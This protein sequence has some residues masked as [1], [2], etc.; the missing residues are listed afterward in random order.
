VSIV[1]DTETTDLLPGGE[2]V[3]VAWLYLDEGGKVSG[4]ACRRFRPNRPITLGAMAV[5]N[6]LPEELESEDSVSEVAAMMA[7]LVPDKGPFYVIGHRPEFDWGILCNVCPGLT[8][9]PLDP[10]KAEGCRV[11]LIDTL[12]MARVLWPEFDSHNLLACAYGLIPDRDLVR[13]LVRQAHNALTDCQLCH[14]ILDFV[15]AKTMGIDTKDGLNWKELW[16]FSEQCRVPVTMPFGKHKGLPIA[17]VPR[18]YVAWLLRQDDVDPYL[19]KALTR[20]P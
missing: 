1:L 17:K 19:R 20:T 10:F 18:D 12:S 9:D 7:D 16:L 5:H 14:M 8:R 4:S 11:R 13:Q 6:I 3:E 2:P 15:I